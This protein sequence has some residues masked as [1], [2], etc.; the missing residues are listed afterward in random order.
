MPETNNSQRQF[1]LIL[2]VFYWLAVIVL[3]V[4]WYPTYQLMAQVI[5]MRAE[6]TLLEQGTKALLLVMLFT[7]M[8]AYSNTRKAQ[9]AEL[10]ATFLLFSLILYFSESNFI[11]S[12]WQP[13][14]GAWFIGLLSWKLLWQDRWSLAYLFVGCGFIGLGIVSDLLLDNPE[15]LPDWEIFGPWQAQAHR[16]EEQFDLWGIA[17]LAYACLVCFRDWIARTLSGHLGELTLLLLS[18][19]LIASGNGFAHW[20][21]NPSP[22][23]QIIASAMALGG[24]FGLTS[25]ERKFE[26]RGYRFTQVDREFLYISLITFFVVLP[27]IYGGSG[28]PFNL[29]LWAVLV[30]Y[31]GKR[32]KSA[33][34]AS[35]ADPS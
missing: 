8:V 21:Y 27:V 32:M 6:Y 25:F 34:A 24:I 31:V 11:S 12:I 28:A 33:H 17:F 9:R 23:F 10:A 19:V 16:I 1:F 22:I 13:L 3:S 26:A 15:V 2:S 14:F 7:S 4:A 20:Q 29:L 30:F 35:Q 18:V 5:Q